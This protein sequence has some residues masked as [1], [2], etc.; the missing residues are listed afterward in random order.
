MERKTLGWTGE[1]ISPLILGSWE[2]GT[3][4]IID[5]ANAVKIIRKAI[6]MGI[7]AIDTAESYGNGLSE[8]VIGRA[9]KQFKRE[10]VFIITKVSIDH[11]RYND[12]LRAAEGSLKRLETNYIDLYLV[13]WPNHYVPIRETAKAM[14]R[15]FNEGKIRY[16]GLSNFSL[17][18]LREFREH[19]SKTDVAANELHYNLLFRDVEKEVL[20]YMQREN[21]PLLAYDSL[22]LGYLVGRKE[23]RNEYRWYVLARE[24]YIRS[25]EPLVNEIS[26]IAKELNKTP[27][28]VVLNWLISKDS[29]F[30]IFNTT[31]EEHLKDNLG[32]IGWKL[33]DN[34]L[35]R[36]D[37]AV[38][39]VIID[40]FVR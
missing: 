27:A 11:L 16:I 39:K 1:K 34:E 26:S 17:P 18:L 13:H 7:N 9:I 3:T 4:S 20:P 29:V 25:I 5:E 35:R 31:K 33:G 32:S 28:Q 40:Y 36:I 30:A 2:Y 23:V 38:K 15:L 10:E 21:I 19:L 12:V 24:T 22:G 6:E 8:I 14:E 37:E